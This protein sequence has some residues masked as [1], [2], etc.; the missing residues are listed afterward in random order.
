MVQEILEMRGIH[1]SFNRV[2]VLKGVDLSV[3]RGEI[4]ALLGENGAGKSTLMNILGGV[5]PPDAGEIIFEGEERRFH[6]PRESQALGIRFIHQEL[7]VIPDLSVSENLFLGAEMVSFRLLRKQ[8]M[9]R[10]A[11]ELLERMDVPIRPDQMVRDLNPSYKQMVEIAKALLFEAKL[12]IM[13]EPTSSLTVHEITRLFQLMRQLKKENVSIIYISHKLKEILEI[14]DR[15]TILRDGEKVDSGLI[16]DVNEEILTKRM[17]GRAW[18][19]ET[20]FSSTAGKRVVLSVEGASSP[21]YHDISF[22][23]HEGEVLGITG[24]SGDGRTELAEGIF[25]YR[26]MIS[27]EIL[28]EGKRVR[29]RHPRDAVREGIAYV[30]KDRKE[31]GILKEM[32]VLHNFS[33]SSLKS[34]LRWGFI[35]ARRERE[36]YEAY[37]EKLNIKTPDERLP[38]VGLSGGNQQKVLLAKW[39]AVQT[40]VLLLD[41]PTQGID[42]GAK[43]EIYQLIQELAKAGKGIVVLSAEFPELRRLC[44]RVIVLFQGR[45]QAVLSREELTEEKVMFFA[46]GGKEGDGA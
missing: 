6:S 2:K 45:I 21:F 42:V 37:K 32:S 23:L 8:E 18:A 16:Q 13:D 27:G 38:I 26:P 11:K 31:N 15:Y 14:C 34:Y 33:I 28:V 30:P 46:M 25:G 29:I 24:L 4:H 43:S 35:H 19:E 44:D 10:R 9:R 41:N 17:V 22:Q 36:E 40:K 1:K 12:I 3:R 5:F 20:R 39:L 7:N